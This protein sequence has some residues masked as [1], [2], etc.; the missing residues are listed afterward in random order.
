MVCVVI[1]IE[2]VF[3]CCF[4]CSCIYQIWQEGECIIMM[5]YCMSCF[6]TESISVISST[7]KNC[8]RSDAENQSK[9]DLRTIG[10]KFVGKWNKF[11]CPC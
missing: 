6:N 11:Q 4:L 5:K 3:C 2:N 8:E 9:F 1:F 7:G 10:E